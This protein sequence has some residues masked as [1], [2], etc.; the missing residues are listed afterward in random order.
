MII[1]SQ[2]QSNKKEWVITSNLLISFFENDLDN[3]FIASNFSEALNYAKENKVKHGLTHRGLDNQYK[4]TGELD[5]LHLPKE[6]SGKYIENL[7]KISG[8]VSNQ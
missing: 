3:K 6:E 7:E 4:N 2:C 5:L 1:V 8:I